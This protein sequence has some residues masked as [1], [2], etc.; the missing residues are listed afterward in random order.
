MCV[1][2][3]N[4]QMYV[5][6]TVQMADQKKCT[7]EKIWPQSET[8]YSQFNKSNSTASTWEWQIHLTVSNVPFKIFSKLGRVSN[9]FRG[10]THWPMPLF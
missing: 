8:L 9:K 1:S 7:A 4:R 10:G 3:M 5:R 6:N 2:V